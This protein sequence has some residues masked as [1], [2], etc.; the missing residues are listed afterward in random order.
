LAVAQAQT[1]RTITALQKLADQGDAS[2]QNE[3]GV[4]YRTGDGVE[5]TY[6]NAVALYRR[7]AKRG[8]AL[9][10]FNLGTAYYNGDGV[11]P[12]EDAACMWFLLASKAGEASGKAAFERAQ[13]DH[14]HDILRCQMSAADAYLLGEEIPK[15]EARAR[16]IYESA[17]AAGSSSAAIRL[18]DVYSLGLGVPKDAN[19]AFHWLQLAIDRHEPPA[20]FLAGRA[21]DQ[22]VI[23]PENPKK[24]CELYREGVQV[25]SSDATLALAH[26]ARDGR[27]T[28]RDLQVAYALGYRAAATGRKDAAGFVQELLPSMSQKQIQASYER[29]KASIIF[30]LPSCK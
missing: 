8:L 22:G 21:Y 19:L 26:L 13:S 24:A 23:V 6:A 27:G 28:K 9:A 17:A 11:P 4:H 5:L 10:Y 2:A 16:T 1:T 12:N 3:L 29:A 7:A 20:Y 30:S 15:D 25:R 14:P 18:W